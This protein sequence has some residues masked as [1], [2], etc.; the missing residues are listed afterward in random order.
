MITT[1]ETTL[2]IRLLL[3]HFIIDFVLQSKKW[4]KHK[5]EN[6]GSSVYL[7]VHAF[8]A[9][10]LAWL[11][12]AYWQ[13]WLVIIPVITVTHGLI[14][15]LK[16]K[17]EKKGSFHK[18]FTFLT[19]QFLHL[20]IIGLLW[21]FLIDKMQLLVVALTG[22]V[23]NNTVLLL[24]LGYILITLPFGYLIG[25]VTNRWA[26]EAYRDDNSSLKNAGKYIGYFERIIIFSFVLIDQFAAIGFLITGKSILR[27]GSNN[28]SKKSE[29]VLV[30]T[31]L[32]NGLAI[33]AGI[34][35][36]KLLS[37]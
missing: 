37:F 27:F 12:S 14:D 18:G 4:V 2:L 15:W 33:L 36:K 13:N 17:I 26:E 34:V 8:L 35:F 22:I 20:I 6:E 28:D 10:L 1:E 21:L 24:V 9:G 30:G 29:Y 11:F 7:Y 5:I 32:S 23:T 25:F 19:D 31:L 16:I 3:S